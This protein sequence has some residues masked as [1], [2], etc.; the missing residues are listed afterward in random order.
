MPKSK[1]QFEQIRNERIKDILKSAT[2]LFALKGYDA[3]NLDEVTKVAKCSHGLLYHYFKG[4]EELYQAVLEQIVYPE[5]KKMISSVKWDQKAKYVVH[6]LL[7]SVLNV[8]K[9]NNDEQ[10]R[11]L[12]LL[13]N[14]HLQKNLPIV[15][16]NEKGRTMILA[17]LEE[18]V[19]RGIKEGDFKEF[20]PFEL[21]ISVLSLLKGLSFTRIHIGY[22][23]FTCPHI[24]IIMGLLL[25]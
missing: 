11:T 23:R 4:K 19:S 13:L 12:Y 17:S 16:K 14:I 21:T 20:D 1:E 22:K 5:C 3:V 18:I 9:S 2:T 6:D 8:I 15:K 10:I 25:K 24:E 7:D